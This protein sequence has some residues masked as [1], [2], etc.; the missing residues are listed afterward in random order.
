MFKRKI[1]RRDM[2]V[3]REKVV[4][5]GSSHAEG[6]KTEVN[7]AVDT[8]RRSPSRTRSFE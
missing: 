8:A 1:H 6:R 2:E 5:A 3:T 7:A 4:V